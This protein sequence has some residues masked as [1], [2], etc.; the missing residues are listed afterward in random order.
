MSDIAERLKDKLEKATHDMT[1]AGCDTCPICENKTLNTGEYVDVGIGCVQ[2]SPDFCEF[3]GYC[4][5]GL[6]T[7][8]QYTYEQFL[9]LWEMQID[10]WAREVQS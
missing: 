9:K 4:Q 6:Y 5:S 8:N 7:E 2:C 10:P 1:V 3:C